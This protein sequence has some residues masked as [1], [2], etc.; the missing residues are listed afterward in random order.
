ME[1]SFE[2][3]LISVLM[4]VWGSVL[5]PVSPIIVSAQFSPTIRV[6][7]SHTDG[8]GPAS[9]STVGK[10]SKVTAELLCHEQVGT[11]HDK[12]KDKCLVAFSGEKR[13]FFVSAENAKEMSTGASA[14]KKAKN[15]DSTEDSARIPAFAEVN[16]DTD[17]DDGV[18]KS[19]NVASVGYT[20]WFVREAVDASTQTYYWTE[21][22]G[23]NVF[24][25]FVEASIIVEKSKV[26]L[27]D[28]SRSMWIML[29]HGACSW[30]TG[31]FRSGWGKVDF[32][33]LAYG[34]FMRLKGKDLA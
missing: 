16:H 14:I 13:S 18:W 6:V 31:S 33:F 3:A 34:N 7:I 32:S 24:A 20:T 17:N 8:K 25:T 26:L 9:S 10:S 12:G 29:E 2:I 11:G 27:Y 28:Q 23:S 21:Y 19:K 30:G 5:S 22:H 15:T 1:T 4:L